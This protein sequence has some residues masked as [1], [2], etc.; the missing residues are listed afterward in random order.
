MQRSWA[1][2]A[3]LLFAAGCKGS[4][5]SAPATDPFFGRTR[6]EPPRTGAVSGALSAGG[7]SSQ[8]PPGGSPMPGGNWGNVAGGSATAPVQG[9]PSGQAPAPAQNWSPAPPKTNPVPAAIPGQQGSSPPPGSNGFGAGGSGGFQTPGPSRPLS[10]TGDRISIPI[11]ARSE[12]TWPTHPGTSPAPST[13]VGAAGSAAQPLRTGNFAS[14]GE[15]SSPG[16]SLSSTASPA[17]STQPLRPYLDPGSPS[18]LEGKERIVREI[19]RTA[20]APGTAPR[21]SP[22]PGTSAASAGNASVPAASVPAASVPAASVPTA[23]DKGVNIADLPES[24]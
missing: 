13:T 12:P 14:G 4:G 11:A 6:I 17:N 5:T 7:N 16:S 2:L 9:N 19:E 1:L 3:L 20:S 15:S 8:A 10:G 24:K 18:S 23:S 22:Y 21:Y